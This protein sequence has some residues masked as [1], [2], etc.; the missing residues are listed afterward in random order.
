[1]IPRLGTRFVVVALA[2]AVCALRSPALQWG[3]T[4]ILVS[5][6]PQALDSA[7]NVL[8]QLESNAWATWEETMPEA[9]IAPLE[10]PVYDPVTNPYPDLSRPFIARGLLKA[11]QLGH[12]S[13]LA[14]WTPEFF[15]A[16]P[17]GLIEVDYF[18]DAREFNTVPDGKAA[19]AAIIQN[20]SGG[21]YEKFGTEM[22]GTAVLHTCHCTCA[23]PSASL[24]SPQPL[25]APLYASLYCFAQQVFR[26]HPELMDALPLSLL[27]RLFGEGYFSA[28]QVGLTLTVPIFFGRGAAGSDGTVTTD[29]HCEPIGNAMIMLQGR[30]TWQ[31]IPPSQSHLLRPSAAPDGRGYIYSTRSPG[32]AAK[33]KLQRFE[34]DVEAGDLLWV[35]PWTWHQVDYV[36]DVSALSVS[37][38]HLRAQELLANN[39]LYALALAPNLVKELFGYKKQ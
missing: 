33:Q 31:L 28:A 30:K 8:S 26:A 25:P 9:A 5:L 1:M 2:V 37:L 7:L 13:G 3:V 21:G 17:Y 14:A 16:P 39:P 34:V 12:S 29:L 22:V 11:G 23:P 6:C 36:E 18:K 32:D 38:F 35:P 15:S 27:G 20:I 19:L 24:H 4:Q 10:I